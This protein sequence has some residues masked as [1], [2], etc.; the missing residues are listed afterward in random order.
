M[1]DLHTHEVLLRSNSSGDLYSIPA[2]PQPQISTALLYF[3]PSLWHKRLAHLNNNDL[4][5]LCSS[6]LIACNND[7]LHTPCQA[8]QLG[9]QI[10][11]P[12]SKSESY[13]SKPLE[14]VHSYV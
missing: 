9:K 11:L 6:H 14:L 12:F 5:S 7:N 10:K 4:N 1:K 8:C 2:S 13:T 3:L